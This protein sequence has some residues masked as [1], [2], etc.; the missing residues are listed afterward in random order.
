MVSLAT[1]EKRVKITITL[2]EIPKSSRIFA[3][4]A[5]RFIPVCDCATS[6]RSSNIE[7]GTPRSSKWIVTAT[8]AL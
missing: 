5:A 2:P 4:A 8:Y 1:V 3:K 7:T 6:T